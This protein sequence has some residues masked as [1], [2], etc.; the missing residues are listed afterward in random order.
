MA[1]VEAQ[2]EIH[3][4]PAR[5]HWIKPYGICSIGVRAEPEVCRNLMTK[6]TFSS[7]A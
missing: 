7:P 3:T 4:S 2:T 1:V 5:A 6:R